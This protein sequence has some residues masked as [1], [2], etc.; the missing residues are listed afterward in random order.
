MP[1]AMI[2]VTAT[3]FSMT[4][5]AAA[6]ASTAGYQLEEWSGTMVGRGAAGEAWDGR[7]K[8]TQVDQIAK[9]ACPT[10]YVLTRVKC[11]QRPYKPFFVSLFFF[12]FILMCS[13]LQS[14]RLAH[15]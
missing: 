1:D 4:P 10:R 15:H 13:Q 9:K 3:K 12:Y 7:Q 6:I 2:M 11:S 5:R 14:F 8:A